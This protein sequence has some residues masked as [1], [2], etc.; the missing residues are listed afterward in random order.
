MYTE[1]FRD[2]P[3][4]RDD[5]GHKPHEFVGTIK[6]CNRQTR[7][8]VLL[9]VYVFDRPS[10]A[11]H[12]C[13]RHG[14]HGDYGSMPLVEYLKIKDADDP[15]YAVSRFLQDKGTVRWARPE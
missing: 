13:V 1:E 11:S 4:H 9:D 2:T 5:C 10:G 15:A 8:F 6:W 3:Y 14:E 7:E 12:V